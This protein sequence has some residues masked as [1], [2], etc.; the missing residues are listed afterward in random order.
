MP[1]IHDKYDLVVTIFIVY[2]GTVLLVNHPRY[3]MWAPVGGHVE[4]DEDPEQALLREIKEETGL[5][6]AFLSTKPDVIS[7]GTK[8]LLTPN[9]LDVHEANPPHKHIALTYF[10]E[11]RDSNAVLSNEHKTLKW[12]KPTELTEGEYNLT[13]M[14]VF[15]AKEALR[16]A[17]LPA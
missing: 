12:F 5:G 6:V 16:I 9:Y 10:A 8:P 15:Y 2:E 13:P 4:L 3:K 17:V 7:P 11:A 1:H 14:I